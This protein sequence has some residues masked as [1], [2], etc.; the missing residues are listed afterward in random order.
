[1]GQATARGGSGRYDAPLPLEGGVTLNQQQL[2]RLL[3]LLE[4]DPTLRRQLETAAAEGEGEFV[5][6]F[7]A[8]GAKV[9]TP[10]SGVDVAALI[11]ATRALSQRSSAELADS[12]LTRVAGGLHREALAT[13]GDDAQLAS[14]DLQNVLQKQQQTLQMMSNI[15][16][17]LHDVAMATIR[18]IGG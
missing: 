12:A 10:L 1:M 7:R 3:E 14:V 4:R 17:M 5:D 13:V 6:A 9:G 16:K 8:A 18:K 2:G 11:D 15:S